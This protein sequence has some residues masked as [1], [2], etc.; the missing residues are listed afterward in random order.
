M[1]SDMPGVTLR[2]TGE[3]REKVRRVLHELQSKT[4]SRH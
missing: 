1:L 3:I 4:R 2:Q